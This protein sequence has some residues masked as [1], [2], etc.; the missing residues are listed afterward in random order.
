VLTPI[1]S[2]RLFAS[3]LDRPASTACRRLPASIE[4][5]SIELSFLPDTRE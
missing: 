3:I 5:L 4:C 1:A 2:Q